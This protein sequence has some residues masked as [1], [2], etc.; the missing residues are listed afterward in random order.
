M[1]DYKIFVLSISK[2][3]QKK[4]ID[5]RYTIFEGVNGK[6]LDIEW[7]NETYHFY[8]NAFETTKRN[9][10]GCSQSHIKCMEYIRDNK[11]NNAII[12]E[13]DALI[14][15]E[16]LEELD[17]VNGFCFIGG[18]FIDHK[19]INKKIETDK[20]R[21]IL[22]PGLN[23]IDTS[24]FNIMN[25]HGYYISNYEIIDELI[26]KQ[27]TKR[28]AIDVEFKNKQRKKI[29]TQFIYPAISILYLPDA[30]TGFTYSIS[31]YPM[32]DNL[33]RY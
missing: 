27:L 18:R 23:I 17:N 2:E 11:I 15:L 20:L 24:M 12:I 22:V 10:A 3:R 4:Y 30:K 16:R 26:K 7:V 21:E 29:I 32:N 13:D 33:Y 8:Y 25:A 5:P 31:N 1:K 28:R 14:D 19:N 6:E 9:I